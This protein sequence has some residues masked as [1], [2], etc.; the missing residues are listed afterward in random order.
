MP[1]SA[2]KVAKTAPLAENP[3][4]MPLRSLPRPATISMM[5]LHCMV[6]M[7]IA[8]AICLDGCPIVRPAEAVAA[9]TASTVE[10]FQSFF[11]STLHLSRPK[12]SWPAAT[13]AIRSLPETPPWRSATANAAGTIELAVCCPQGV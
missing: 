13:A 8:L 6:A 3:A 2:I 4:Y 10:R 1:L 5:P 7:P 11:Q 9:N 12:M